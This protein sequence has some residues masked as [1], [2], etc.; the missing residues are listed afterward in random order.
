[1][2]NQK[3]EWIGYV[4]RIVKGY[5]AR[6]AEL[7][8]LKNQKLTPGY[9]KSGGSGKTH[10]KTEAVALRTLP[11][12][13]QQKHDAVERSLI[14]TAQLQDGELRCRFVELY[15]FHSHQQKI[16]ID[17]TARKLHISERTA[18]RWN[19]DFLYLVKKNMEK[20]DIL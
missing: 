7:M 2:S 15:Y 13:E 5:P 10:R 11:G 6:H 19:K 9:S 12:K 18:L 16:R 1:M 3:N 4:K 8:E 14:K 20:L 17:N